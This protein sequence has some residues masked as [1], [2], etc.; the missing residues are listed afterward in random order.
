MMEISIQE[1]YIL[2]LEEA[3]IYFHIGINKLHK[4]V[5]DSPSA[6]WLLMNGTHAYI[7]RKK[8][9]NLIDRIGSI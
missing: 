3:S 7:K 9:E 4:L 8:F 5:R 2:S 1:K 6:D